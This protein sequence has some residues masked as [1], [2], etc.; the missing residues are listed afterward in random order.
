LCIKKKYCKDY[1]IRG[2]GVYK[3]L[4]L[5]IR[6]GGGGQNGQKIDYVILEQ[7]LRYDKKILFLFVLIFENI[8]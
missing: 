7:S 2:G 5:I 4:H 8:G 6:G 3:L 1:V